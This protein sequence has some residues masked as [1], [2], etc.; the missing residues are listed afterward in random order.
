M[1]DEIQYVIQ[2]EHNGKQGSPD[3]PFRQSSTGAGI[4]NPAFWSAAE[5][6]GAPGA[7]FPSIWKDLELMQVRDLLH[8][9]RLGRTSKQL[10]PSV[11]VW[12]P[13]RGVLAGGG[14]GRSTVLE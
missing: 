2:D 1:T 8:R 7:K 13:L 11:P 3:E 6:P 12:G 5:S 4:G 9:P 10:P 14:R